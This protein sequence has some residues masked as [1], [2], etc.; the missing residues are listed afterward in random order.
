MGFFNE[1]EREIRVAKPQHAHPELQPRQRLEKPG[2]IIEYVN[3]PGPLTVRASVALDEI[4]A[5]ALIWDA[6]GSQIRHM[7]KVCR[8]GVDETCSKQKNVHTTSSEA[9]N[10]RNM[11]AKRYFV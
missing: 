5:E 1:R 9:L 11:V 4:R 10:I 8:H 3:A 2:S 7:H 6:G